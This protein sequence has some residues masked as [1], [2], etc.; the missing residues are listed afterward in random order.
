M[1]QFGGF[2]LAIYTLDIGVFIYGVDDEVIFILAIM[3]RMQSQY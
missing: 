3:D 2:F 1:L